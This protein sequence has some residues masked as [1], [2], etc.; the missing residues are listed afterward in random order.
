M[1]KI[2]V[3]MTFLACSWLCNAQMIVEDPG[4]IAQ[5]ALN[6]VDQMSEAIE[7]KYAMYEQ[8]EQ[9]VQQAE[10][11]KKN[12]DKFKKV[13]DWVKQG[14]EVISIIQTVEDINTELNSFR[15]YLRNSTYLTENEQ[16]VL[17]CQGFDVYSEAMDFIK[18]TQK[19]I[20]DFKNEDDAGLSSAERI[21]LLQK[22]KE[23]VSSLKM[24]LKLIR[25][26]ANKRI[27]YKKTKCDSYYNL[28]NTF[29]IQ[30]K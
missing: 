12:M 1:R 17:Y 29:N 11:V 15:K 19:Y 7:E 27:Q 20:S 18:E 24:K 5:R 8:I 30:V 9:A 16:Y 2:F 13:M 6:F 3:V 14:K 4:G 28:A 10:L 21:A 26:D 25:T 23:D 22:V